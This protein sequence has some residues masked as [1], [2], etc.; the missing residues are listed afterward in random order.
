MAEA[1]RPLDDAFRLLAHLD[2]AAVRRRLG[3]TLDD[4]DRGELA[5]YALLGRAP[6]AELIRFLESLHAHSRPQTLTLRSRQAWRPT[7]GSTS[8]QLSGPD[9]SCGT[10]V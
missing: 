7:V 3:K 5:A 2:V 9:T 6:D 8:S 1:S 4:A 10:A